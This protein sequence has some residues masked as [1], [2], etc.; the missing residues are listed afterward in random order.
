MPARE[1][2]QTVG[3]LT[4]LFLLAWGLRLL[5]FQGCILGDD[6]ND[7]GA[8]QAVLARSVHFTVHWELRI[9]LWFFI[10]LTQKVFGVSEWSLF[11]S[12]WIFSS[13]L[14]LIAYLTMT[15]FGYGRSQ[16]FLA[17]LFVATAPYE[18]LIGSLHSS[19]LFLEWFFALGFLVLFTTMRSQILHGV[20]LALVLWGAFYNKFWWS[21]FFGPVIAVYFWRR[22]RVDHDLTILFSCSVSTVVLH[23]ITCIFWKVETGTYF[24]FVETVNIGLIPYVIKPADLWR[25]FAVYPKM[26]FQGS[27][28]HTT[29]FGAVPYLFIGFLVIKGGLALGAG[30]KVPLDAMDLWLLLFN[31]T[32]CLFINYFPCNFKFD[33]Y[34][35][36]TRIFRYLAPISFP[37][38]LHT[39]KLAVDL[40]LAW[41]QR[42]ANTSAFVKAFPAVVF[43]ILLLSVNLGQAAE[44]TRP[45]RA[46]RSAFLNGV[47]EVRRMKPPRVVVEC[48]MSG[49][50]RMHLATTVP[51]IPVTG[52]CEPGGEARSYEAWIHNNEAIWEP[53]TVLVTGIG[54]YVH[55]GGHH[56]GPRLRLFSQPLSPRWTLY[57]EL[58][59][60]DYVP[61]PEFAALW[62]L[63]PPSP[64][65]Q[66]AHL[67]RIGGPGRVG[68]FLQKFTDG[69]LLLDF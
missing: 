54:S 13:S 65:V 10:V 57:K 66:R 14:S 33:H 8:V 44:A 45:G 27:E 62:V 17:G 12:T 20:L 6:P 18:V 67:D 39:G 68:E 28:F 21:F 11:L 55:Y 23:L 2:W 1:R 19:D 9:F 56:C 4:T 60:Q 46:Y 35:S 64:E 31:G 36:S 22:V 38:A 49:F 52:L 5:F 41:N 3:H 47:R 15:R 32:L 58:G 69:L 34:Y 30:R 40:A 7:I 50:W 24:P 51:L 43:W 63:Q 37:L 25:T 53:G 61:T 59:L 29:L 26:L 16:A 48:W 42:F